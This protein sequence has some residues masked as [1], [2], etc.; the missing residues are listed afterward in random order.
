[1]AVTELL[2]AF[3]AFIQMVLGI[4]ISIA[5]VYVGIRLYDKMTKG[6]EE[7]EEI[8]KGNT[9]VG[10]F[11]ASVVFAIAMI[12]QPSVLAI[13]SG[14]REGMGAGWMVL[15]LIIGVVNLL[16]SLCLAVIAVYV[17]MK[18]IDSMTADIDELEELQ[19]GNVAMGA[20][21][22]GVMVAVSLI[23]NAGMQ[24]VMKLAWL[25]VGGVAAEL[26]KYGI[27]V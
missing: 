10:I 20:F 6:I 12:T 2:F 23:M 14:F 27:G 25:D 26:A 15:A 22:A 3:G 21:M 1:V 4:A 5:V 9:A 11:M 19:K 18:V 7:M 17:A 16:L 24:G 13:T 8:K